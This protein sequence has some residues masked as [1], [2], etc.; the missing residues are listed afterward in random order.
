MLAGF[1]RVF[2]C[3]KYSNSSLGVG[4]L[5][6]GL[7]NSYKEKDV[8]TDLGSEY[9]IKDEKFTLDLNGDSIPY[10]LSLIHI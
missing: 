10:T 6:R 5:C 8:W 1:Q 9:Q 7:I 3:Y 4:E 2:S